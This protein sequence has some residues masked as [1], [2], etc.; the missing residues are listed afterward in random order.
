MAGYDQRVFLNVPFDSR[1][2]KL[3]AA[4][5]FAVHD[6]GFIARCALEIDD[7]GESRLSK[8]LELIAQC[9]F[10]VHDLSRTT[11]DR[12]TG[13]PRFNMP[14]ERGLFL[15]AKRF[16]GDRQRRK[17]TLILERDRYRYQRFCSDLAGY[18]IRAHSN[19]V[20]QAIAAIRNWLHTARPHLTIPGGAK[21]RGRYGAFRQ[22]L[23]ALCR[24]IGIEE[25]ELTFPARRNLVIGW[26]DKNP[27]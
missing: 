4:L 1:Y 9:G 10:G 8:I 7:S 3:F 16:G 14:L 24:A 23:P 21:M 27:W 18:D 2:R 17:S 5:V 12:A 22:Q 19:E 13:L 25:G 15:G 20:S 26:L 11:C 6:C